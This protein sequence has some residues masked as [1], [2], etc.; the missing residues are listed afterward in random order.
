MGMTRSHRFFTG[1]RSRSV[2]FWLG[3]SLCFTGIYITLALWGA[4]PGDVVGDN[5]REYVSWMYR[6][7]HPDLFPHDLIADYFQSITPI[8]YGGL[9]RLLAFLGVDPVLASKLLPIFVAFLTTCYGFAVCLQLLPVPMAGFITTLVLNQS[10]AMHDDFVSGTPRD[11]IY[12]LFLAFLYYLFAE[13]FLP[14]LVAIALVGLFYPPMAFIIAGVLLWRWRVDLRLCVAGVVVAGAVVLPFALQSTAFGPTVTAAV[15][16]TMP[17]YLSGGRVS[18]FHLS[19]LSFWLDGRDSGV[20]ALMSP[21]QLF[22]G[23]LLPFLSRFPQQFPLTQRVNQKVRILIAVVCASLVM[24]FI[25]HGV[26]FKLHW[27]SRY[28]HHTF[29]IV[30]ALCAGISITI[31]LDAVFYWA[32]R[33]ALLITCGVLAGLML[34]PLCLKSFPTTPFVTSSTP[35]LYK[36]LQTQ[37]QNSLIASLAGETDNIPVFAQRSI[38]VGKEYALPIHT[39][40]YQQFR[41]RMLD[42]ITAQYSLD[43][44]QVKAFI[45]KY[46]V[47]LWVIERSAFQ[48][49]YLTDN[50]F[51]KQYQPANNQA[52]AH[53]QEGTPAISKIMPTC[54]VFEAKGLVVLNAE[55]VAE[56]NL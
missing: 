47:N 54:T 52:I 39:K 20:L 22:V 42:L 43:I 23:W 37:P 34:F 36:F 6:Y 40:Y 17:E 55:C 19:L 46:A 3:V 35:E 48:K 51:L 25:A 49:E 9:F 5:A 50:R 30:F 32:R 33:L 24:F 16:K 15:A 21:P 7:R 12:P 29:R 41:Q 53:L 14:C 44:N 10:L 38:L 45:N 26:A 11:F 56:L 1:I 18:Y 31:M 28:T 4:F 2:I 13:A 8:G 27:P